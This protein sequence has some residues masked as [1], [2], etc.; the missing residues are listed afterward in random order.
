[1]I[2]R[3]S[4]MSISRPARV[5]PTRSRRCDSDTDA[6]CVW[7][8]I[9]IA[10]SSSGSSSGSNSPSSASTS[11]AKTS[12]RSRLPKAL[13]ELERRLVELLL[14]L[15]PALLDDERDLLLRHVRA[16][17]ALQPGGA[18]RLEEH[19]ALAEQAL[20]AGLVEDHA[21][22]RLRRNGERDPR[23][24]VR[25]DHSGDHVDRRALRCEH[26]MDSHRARLLREANDGVLDGLGR[27]H[28]IG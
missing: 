19:V 8:T 12:G 7:T 13:R 23:R 15:V 21:R 27:D 18:E 5:Y 28:Q 17:H 4:S 1:M 2:P 26:E 6:V 11:S 10:F 20:G 25:L 9:S 24:N 3:R 22:V 14:A 16:L